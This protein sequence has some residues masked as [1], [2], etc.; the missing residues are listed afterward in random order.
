MYEIKFKKNDKGLCKRVSEGGEINDW[1][2]N[3]VYLIVNGK[4][5]WFSLI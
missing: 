4:I 3:I 2:D 1:R 5:L